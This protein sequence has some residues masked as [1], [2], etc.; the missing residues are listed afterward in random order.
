M[1]W[2]EEAVVPEN[3]LKFISKLLFPLAHVAQLPLHTS[4]G[5]KKSQQH[6][7]HVDTSLEAIFF[8]LVI[9]WANGPLNNSGLTATSSQYVTHK[10]P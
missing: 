7:L 5:C 2:K 4:H 1:D 6:P 10:I 8:Y 3:Y 9:F